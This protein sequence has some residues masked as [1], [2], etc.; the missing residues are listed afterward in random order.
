MANWEYF[1][2]SK[3][4]RYTPEEIAQR[5]ISKGYENGINCKASVKQE[6]IRDHFIIFGERFEE[7]IHI[8]SGQE[9]VVFSSGDGNEENIKN[10]FNLFQ[11]RDIEVKLN[12][13]FGDIDYKSYFEDA[14]IKLNGKTYFTELKSEKEMMSQ[15][16]TPGIHFENQE[17]F[18]NHTQ[19]K[20]IRYHFYNCTF[21]D[22][23]FSKDI[24]ISQLEE[25]KFNNCTFESLD[26]KKIEANN[27][28][29]HNCQFN[30]SDFSN[31]HFLSNKFYDC[32]FFGTNLYK[33]N[34]TFAEIKNTVF[35]NNTNLSAIKLNGASMENTYFNNC[36]I[37][38]AVEGLY[39]ENIMLS[40]ATTEEAAAYKKQVF[41]TLKLEYTS[42]SNEI[43]K[44]ADSLE[45]LPPQ[46]PIPSDDLKIYDIAFDNENYMHFSINADGYRLNGLFR[47][48]DPANGVSMELVSIDN[49]DKH[50]AI[51]E[52]WDNI[53]QQCRIAA[54]EKYNELIKTA[55]FKVISEFNP[56]PNE[57][58]TWIRN[59]EDIKTFEDALKDSDWENW[60]LK[61]FDDSYSAFDAEN[62]LK[63]GKIKV[64]SSHPI[65]QGIF[66]T[67]SYMEAYSYS[68]N[69]KVY[70]KVVDLDD[71]AWIDPTQ[72]QYASVKH[73]KSIYSGEVAIY[74]DGDNVSI[75]DKYNHQ[76]VLRP[77]DNYSYAN[78]EEYLNGIATIYPEYRQYIENN[79]VELNNDYNNALQAAS[80]ETKGVRLAQLEA[81]MYAGGGYGEDNANARAEAEISKLQN[82]LENDSSSFSND[83]LKSEIAPETIATEKATINI[84][85]K[86][87]S[88]EEFD[89]LT[90][91]I[92]DIAKTYQS[93][94]KLLID[95]IAF[96]SQFYQYS[97]TNTMLIHL[98]NPHA[99]FVGSFTF[100]KSKGYS[101][102]K[103]Q[104]HIKISRPIETSKFPKEINGKTVWTDIK[105][106]SSEEK[107]KIAE[108]KLEIR[109]STRFIPHQVFDISQ[110]T[111][112]AEDYPK[113][114]NMGHPDME[115]HQLY[116]CIK[117][118]AKECGFS[119]TEDDLSSISLHGYYSKSDN[120]I[121]I[122]SL[123]EDSKRLET[124]CHELAHGVLHKT[125]TQP[126]EILEFEA[127]CF[128][129]MLKRK[130][131]FPVSEESKRYI[132][133]YFTKSNLLENTKFDVDKTLNRLSKTFN[134]ISKGIE[135][136]MSNM[137]FA[138]E[139]EIAPN[140]SQAK[141]NAVNPLKIS[142]NFIQALS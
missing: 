132:N 98:Q 107:T 42:F 68:S 9:G 13:K 109:K 123:L 128:G 134:H 39:S 125:S 12:Y 108:G 100:W 32:S 59:T 140:L 25:C 112:P 118:Y 63:I 16:H 17:Q 90:A 60:E 103:G 126:V 96:K 45:P 73:M 30:N 116:D 117:Q 69:G 135:T 51:S 141:N 104:H 52:Q 6:I 8:P 71:V 24:I 21:D 137:G 66:V 28:V 22:I 48:L 79:M 97:P 37:T 92:K 82:E 101:I 142:E 83:I 46:N 94:P 75:T 122:N 87:L 10:I 106:A 19:F 136:T 89:K 85:N 11:R 18:D 138:P 41:E 2:Y 29:F 5:L 99:T 1:I 139:K 124:M 74:F 64:Y 84:E 44:A 20:N 95:Y 91:E 78:I 80:D 105:Y 119:E 33:A 77:A 3:S 102:K 113:F 61:G 4:G 114:Y 65:D 53:E 93:D 31:G 62:A 58:Q 131:G 121:H 7:N 27:S 49:G 127:E 130:M 67:P 115:Q 55:Q 23:H 36:I 40:G 111:C 88:K 26:A 110:T 15:S 76:I 54:I 35:N 43:Q 57:Y 56:A 34:L 70:S 86:Q 81:D 120:S 129:T 47:I 72:G 14:P 133:Q 38:E 50:A